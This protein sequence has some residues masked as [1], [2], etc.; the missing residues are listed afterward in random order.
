MTNITSNN[1]FTKKYIKIHKK[2]TYSYINHIWLISFGDR[3]L[4]LFSSI[5]S[6][7]ITPSFTFRP[8]FSF[9]SFFI[10]QPHFSLTS[11]KITLGMVTM[12]VGVLAGPQQ[13]RAGCEAYD[14]KWKKKFLK[15]CAWYTSF[16]IEKFFQSENF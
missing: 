14:L 10:F 2:Y 8:H 11:R 7:P 13:V 12:G 15:A 16:E 3:T 1:K 4:N 5:V 9:T 6:S